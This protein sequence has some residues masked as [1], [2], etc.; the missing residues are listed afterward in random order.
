MKTKELIRLLQE[1]DP[2]GELEVAV[3]NQPIYTVA[4]EPAYYDGNL[5]M[6]IQDHSVETYN[7]IGYK[8][9]GKGSKVSLTTMDLESVL[10]DE[11]DAPVDLSE[12]EGYSKEQWEKA[13]TKTRKEVLEIIKEV[14]E[15]M[16]ARG[17]KKA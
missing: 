2:S 15:R 10:L 4:A 6:L 7:I 9:T 8:V 11:P 12:L 13:V 5:Q 17:L 3:N 14:D 16:T 1:N